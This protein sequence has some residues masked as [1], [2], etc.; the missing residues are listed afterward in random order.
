MQ[1]SFFIV[2]VFMLI[3]LI[4]IAF[5]LFAIWRAIMGKS[6]V[7]LKLIVSLD[8]FKKKAEKI[9]A[10]FSTGSTAIDGLKHEVRELHRFLKSDNNQKKEE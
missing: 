4:L 5:F 8:M 6:T 2:A 1:I 10:D 3:V 7:D 9:S